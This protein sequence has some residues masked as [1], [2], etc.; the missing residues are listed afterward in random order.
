MTYG[1]GWH[2]NHHAFPYSACHGLEWWQ[3]DVTWYQI[4]LL[5]KLGL[6][7]DVMLPSEK[8]LAAKASSNAK[9]IVHVNASY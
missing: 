1:E 4:K 9:N 6:V 5:E 7:W 2:N 3:I 8:A